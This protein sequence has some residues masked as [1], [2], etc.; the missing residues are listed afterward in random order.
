MIYINSTFS[1]SNIFKYFLDS[2]T[3]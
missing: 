3:F 2:R 1:E